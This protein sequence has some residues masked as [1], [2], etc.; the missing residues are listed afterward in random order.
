MIKLLK[1]AVPDEALVANEVYYIT[2]TTFE[3][4]HFYIVIHTA[5]HYENNNVLKDRK[6][7]AIPA[8]ELDRHI[9][10]YATNNGI[11]YEITSNPILIEPL[12]N[13][14]PDSTSFDYD[15]QMYLRLKSNP[16]EFS[17]DPFEVDLRFTMRCSQN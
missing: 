5:F 14:D 11:E 3:N 17:N 12:P 16:E 15:F 2:F 1:T 13:P 4:S 7:R 6:G 9:G 8:S 10:F